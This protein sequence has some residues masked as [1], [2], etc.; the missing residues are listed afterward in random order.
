MKIR[1]G[2]VSNSSSSS[3][4]ILFKDDDI[5]KCKET[6]KKYEEY[7]TITSYNEYINGKTNGKE[8]VNEMLKYFNLSH[9][10]NIIEELNE[11]IKYYE[12]DEDDDYKNDILRDYYLQSG[13]IED[14]K[15]NGFEHFFRIDFG[16]NHGDISGEGMG[17]IM[18]YEGRNLHL[19][20]DDIYLFTE[21]NR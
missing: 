14:L 5:D 4:I 3:F 11:D 17:M 2:F 15:K 7:F 9:V 6:L 13:L 1:T 20:K 8:V 10:D 18:D 16:D 12:D 19:S 21:Q